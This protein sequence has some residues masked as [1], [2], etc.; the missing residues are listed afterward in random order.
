MVK[1]TILLAAFLLVSICAAGQTFSEWIEPEVN[2]VNRLPMH[3]SF[4]DSQSQR[5]SLD[6]VWKFKFSENADQRPLDFFDLKY[7]DARWGEMT[8]P[9]DWELNGYGDPLYVNIGYAWK[10]WF[11]NNPP[12]V[13]FNRNHVGS[14]RRWFTIPAEWKG[15]QIIA[16]F[17]A[18]SSNIY[19]W[20][21]GKFVG[22]GEDSK[23]ESEFDIT[24]FVKPGKQNLIA[25]QVFRWCDG[26]Y[27]EDQDMFRYSGVS[28]KSYLYTRPKNH[29]E[30]VRVDASLDD[31]Y[32]DG[33][34]KV[35]ADLNF[36][37]K[38]RIELVDPKG[39]TV[40]STTAS[41]MKASAK[42]QV[43]NPARWS[44][45]TPDLYQV[46]VS[47][48]SGKKTV[49]TITVNAGFRRVEIRGGQLLVN[50][51]PV[52]IKGA[53]RHEM[54]PLTGNVMTEKR[55][56]EDIRLMKRFNINAV[57]TCHYPDDSRWYDLC[58]RY[59]IYVVAE[60]DIESHGM[61]YGERSL[62]KDG[63]YLNV[64]LERN[65]RNVQRNRNHPSVI[66]WSLGNEGGYGPNFEAAYDLVK[67]LDPTRPVQYERAGYS[68]KTDICCPMYVKHADLEKYCLDDSKTKPM[69]QCEYAH[70]M[71]NSLGGFREYWEIIRKYP[72]TQG[73]FIWDFVDQSPRIERNGKT[74][75]AYGG[76]W[77][78]YDPS[79]FNFCD[80]GLVS[81]DRVPNPHMYEAG[82]YYQNIWSSLAA[83]EQVEVFN[84]F[85]FKD[86][87]NYTLDWQLLRDGEPVR[88]GSVGTIE[89]A[90]QERCTVEVPYGEIDGKSEWHLNLS[91]KARK[92]EGLVDAGQEVAHQQ[93]ALREHYETPAVTR[94]GEVK[95]RLDSSNDLCVNAEGCTV[96]FGRDGFIREI[97]RGG[98]NLLKEGESIRPSFWRAPTDNDFGAS[99]QTKFEAWHNP[100]IRLVSISSE[101]RRGVACIF[102]E[103]RITHCGAALKMTYSINGAGRIQIDEELVP[104]TE[105]GMAPL[106]R[107]GLRVPLPKEV[108]NLEYY[109]RGPWE[110]YRDR[111]GSAALA[112]YRQ[113]V[114]DQFYRYIR[115]QETGN[116]C[117]IRWMKL[118]DSAGHGLKVTSSE[119]FSASALHYNVETLDEGSFKCNRH[120]GELSED[121]ITCLLVDKL[122][123]GLGCVNSWGEMPLEKDMLPFGQYKA[124]FY[125]E[126]L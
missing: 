35:E 104:G 25:F 77:N 75:Y 67:S 15:E 60:A 86:L 93:I 43:K 101:V 21:N 10:G 34:L 109:G 51:R 31:R 68:G 87:S 119:P 29:I 12:F 99:L 102:A 61:G 45:E 83:P 64:H 54:D 106:F 58:D 115:P 124:T 1:R 38:V 97:S 108:E 63:R 70:A 46:R 120:G 4:S 27:F 89:A 5:L 42:I 69:I 44:A 41:G 116:K 24:G 123:M 13:P 113:T 80:N 50:G 72:K 96:V 2:E 14:Y 121:N 84:E 30:D 9:G 92:A 112:V 103:Y 20:V 94:N 76:D 40:A 85:F 36:A 114:S 39:S 88:E 6:G 17:G 66:V 33:I 90:P 37:G 47:L 49:Q 32:A 11:E 52:L 111:C 91:Y 62:A 65:R 82:Y 23:L 122:Q 98:R 19:L 16:H 3:T 79:D 78:R 26:T 8:V 22:Y 55:M 95:F 18:V 117:D 59:G 110:N 48:L 7:S 28:R 126:S 118:S 73:G 107:F 53:D 57:R 74:I 105:T 125:I 56:L 81:P 100:D 71:G